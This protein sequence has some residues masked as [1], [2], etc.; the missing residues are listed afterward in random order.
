MTLQA[1]IP[2]N[3]LSLID[4]SSLVVLGGVFTGVLP[5]ATAVV[6]FIWVCVRLYETDTI[7]CLVHKRRCPKDESGN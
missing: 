3:V 6:T 4:L 2:G 7:Q 1:M 5:T